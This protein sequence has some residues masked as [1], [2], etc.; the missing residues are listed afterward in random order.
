MSLRLI[1]ALLFGIT[2]TV[3]LLWLGTWQMQRLTWKEAILAEADCSVTDLAREK[4]GARIKVGGLVTEY[5]K[6]RSRAGKNIAFATLSDIESKVELLLFDLDG[7]EKQRLI[8]L[9]EVVMVRGTIDQSEEGTKIRVRD[10][11]IFNP[12][13]AQI[14]K[15]KEEYEK[16]SEPFLMKVSPEQMSL[17]TL[18]EM[19]SV[20]GHHQGE[21]DVVVVVS[22]EREHKLK[23]GPDYRVR[24]SPGLAT[25]IDQLFGDGTSARAA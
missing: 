23:L 22:G 8:Q 19:K 12:S 16:K 7:S 5:R 1:L 18:E 21:S 6:I 25:E 13:E 15:A 11:E 17:D 10:A 24:R 4:D 9:D 2:G 3:V 20:F 14:E